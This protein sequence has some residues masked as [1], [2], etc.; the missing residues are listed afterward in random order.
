[1]EL[2]TIEEQVERDSRSIR[3]D[4]EEKE[5]VFKIETK[6]FGYKERN[7]NQRFGNSGTTDT[8]GSTHKDK[9]LYPIWCHKRSKKHGNMMDVS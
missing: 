8:L 6:S 3:Y 4:I 9:I 5:Q 2:L 7:R 1:M